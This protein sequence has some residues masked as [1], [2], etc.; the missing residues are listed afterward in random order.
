MAMAEPLSVSVCLAV[1]T[2]DEQVDS[3]SE[4]AVT[5]EAATDDRVV[6]SSAEVSR[7]VDVDAVSSEK[8][9]VSQ[10]DDSVV[11]GTCLLIGRFSCVRYVFV[12]LL[13]LFYVF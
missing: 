4:A 9:R 10:L 13:V 6:S 5:D 7:N 1:G 11:S 2:S 12:D 8:E 3:D